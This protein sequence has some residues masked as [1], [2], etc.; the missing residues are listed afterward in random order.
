MISS[1][2]LSVTSA[3]STLNV[4]SCLTPAG[5][6][7]LFG[8]C[9]S[10]DFVSSSKCKE[11]AYVSSVGNEMFPFLDASS[12]SLIQS[13]NRGKLAKLSFSV[14]RF[15]SSIFFGKPSDVLPLR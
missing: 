1:K 7:F 12:I 15:H 13:S 3:L 2:Y 4:N 11:I 14:R 9:P 5:Y 8:K 6:D 10:R